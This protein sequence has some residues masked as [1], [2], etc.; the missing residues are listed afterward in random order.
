[1][2]VLHTA[3]WHVGKTLAGHSRQDEHESVLEEIVGIARDREVDVVLVAGDLFDT[4]APGPDAERIVYRALL[5]LSDIG[6]VVVVPGNH[7][8]E[9]RLAAIAPLFALSNA[10]LHPFLTQEPLEIET[11]AG[12]RARIALLPWLSQR[13]II[14]ADQLMAHDPHE[15]TGQFNERMR[16]IIAALTKDFAADAVNIVLAH[17]T[18]ANAQHGGGER[19]A[20]TIFDYWIDT[21]AFPPSAH[22]VALGHIHKMQRMPGPCPI[23]YS[24]SPLQL[25]FSDHDDAKYVVVFEASRETPS[26]IDEVPLSSGRKLR[27]LRGPLDRL[28]PLSGTT[29]D[30]YLRIVV[31]G[32]GHAG[33]SDEIRELFPAAVKIIIS[34]TEER[35]HR[36][37]IEV[38]ETSPRELFARY[39]EEERGLKDDAILELFQELYEDVVT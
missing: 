32:P 14:K 17:V 23:Q 27:T 16:R 28:A 21:T 38:S 26:D 33:L 34:P 37:T 15:L 3:D 25:D 7:D 2:R 12:E 24:G 29:G 22:Y 9:R 39:L 11:A 35:A 10:T 8:N 36:R 30:D 20:Q 4:T 6:R 18:I 13:H 19:L 1:V 5:E 31:E